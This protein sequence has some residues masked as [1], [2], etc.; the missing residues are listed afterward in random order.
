[1][2]TAESFAANPC[3]PFVH[4]D[5][6][7]LVIERHQLSFCVLHLF[8]EKCDNILAGVSGFFV[9]CERGVQEVRI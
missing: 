5:L 2:S 1:M 9:R 3:E 6:F 7:A 8:V 4:L